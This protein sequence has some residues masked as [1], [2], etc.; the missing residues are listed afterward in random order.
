MMSVT[1][2][3]QSGDNVYGNV[4]MSPVDAVVQ[5]HADITALTTREVDANGYLKPGVLLT[6]AGA[7]IAAMTKSVPDAGTIASGGAGTTGNGVIS[8]V[9][10]RYGAPA[11]SIVVTMTGLGA[12]A[13]FRVE[14]TKSGYLGT[15]AVGTAF[16][17]S[18][19]GFLIADGATD[20]AIG[21]TVTFVVTGGVSDKAFGVVHEAVK[22]A[23]GNAAGDLSAASASH[24]LGVAVAGVINRDIAEDNLA[25]AYTAAELAGLTGSGLQISNT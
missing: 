7:L 5:I 15:G 22:V 10:G 24:Q 4:M 20:F 12:T 11:E 9:S 6:R 19:I 14:G 1:R 18:V 13:A 25:S 3:S 2:P 21:N 23:N 8:A 16:D 17:S